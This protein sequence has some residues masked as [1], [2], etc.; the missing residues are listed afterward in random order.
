MYEGGFDDCKI[1]YVDCRGYYDLAAEIAGLIL[2]GVI[3]YMVISN[4]REL[5]QEKKR[6]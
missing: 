1:P 3:A 2:T 5:K 4:Y 6:F